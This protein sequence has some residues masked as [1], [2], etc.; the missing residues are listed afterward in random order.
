MQ[1][2]VVR[3]H[4]CAVVTDQLFATVAEVPKR[5]AVE[6]TVSFSILGTKMASKC[7]TSCFTVWIA[8]FDSLE[9]LSKWN[10]VDV[11][12]SQDIW[13]LLG[14]SFNRCLLFNLNSRGVNLLL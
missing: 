4:D 6:D 9:S 10:V 8:T 14:W 5:L 12:S 13:L 2:S 3:S 7:E 11:T 1:L